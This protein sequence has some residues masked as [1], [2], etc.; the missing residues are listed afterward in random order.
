M[1][2]AQQQLPD[3]ERPGYGIVWCGDGLPHRLA[4]RFSANC[5]QNSEINDAAALDQ[6]SLLKVTTRHF[7][8]TRI[9]RNECSRAET[10]KPGGSSFLE[11]ALRAYFSA[12]LRVS[13]AKRPRLSQD[14]QWCGPEH[15]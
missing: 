4:L 5:S 15:R 14:P 1:I 11:R 7:L 6:V 10:W 2:V 13:G 12:A 8:I 3:G 9:P